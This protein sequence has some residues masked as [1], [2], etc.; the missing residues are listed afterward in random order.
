MKNVLFILLAFS[1]FIS[2]STQLKETINDIEVKVNSFAAV[3]KEVGT[4]ISIFDEKDI[5]EKI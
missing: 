5:E 4:D 1:Y 2:F 3:E